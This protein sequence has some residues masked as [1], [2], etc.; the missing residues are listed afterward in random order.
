MSLKLI[1]L[2][3]RAAKAVLIAAAIASAV[4]VWLLVRW[5]FANAVTSRIDLKRPESRQVIDFL[6]G[7]GPSDPQSHYAA[8]A[9]LEKTFDPADL[10][11]SLTEYETA[12]ALAPNNYQAWINVGRARDLNGDTDGAEE[13]L[14]RALALAPNYASVQWNYGNFMIRQGRTAEGFELAAKAAASNSEFARSAVVLAMQ[15]FSGDIG[16]VK[17]ALGESD[18]INAALTSTLI[19]QERYDEAVDSWSKLGAEPATEDYKRLSQTLAE[20]LLAAKR[21]R[22][23]ARVSQNMVEAG[24]EKPDVGKIANGGFENGIKLHGA[25]I[26]EWQIADGNEPQVGLSETQKRSGKYGLFLVF[27][28]LDSAQFRSISQM[29]AVNPG[30]EY[31][32]EGYYRSDLKTNTALK[33]EIADAATGAAIAATPPLA[34]AGDWASLRFRFKAPVASDGVIVRLSREAC[35]GTACR[36]AGRLAFD[37]FVL[38]GI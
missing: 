28:T 13:A 38:K 36:I 10:A 3:P 4:F 15:I 35:Q 37:D 14:N 33:I 9:I 12:A 2:E 16:Q 7:L 5:N 11:R 8:A 29:I 22:L 17:A 24:A 30:S 25:K 21:F 20:R 32:F 31:E 27:N 19:A 6:V 34:L 18:G 23:A 26:F 1:K